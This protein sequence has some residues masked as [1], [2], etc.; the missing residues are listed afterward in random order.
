MAA[1]MIEYD[2][3]APKA[4]A[5]AVQRDGIFKTTAGLNAHPRLLQLSKT[6]EK[7]Y[8]LPNTT[9]SSDRFWYDRGFSEALLMLDMNDLSKAEARGMYLDDLIKDCGHCIPHWWDKGLVD[10]LKIWRFRSECRTRKSFDARPH[11]GLWT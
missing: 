2:C 8:L 1:T 7:R 3:E 9:S 4:R 5:L 10:G 6:E 11:V